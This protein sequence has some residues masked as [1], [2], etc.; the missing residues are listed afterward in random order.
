MALFCIFP[1]AETRIDTFIH[2]LGNIGPNPC[3]PKEISVEWVFYT[4]FA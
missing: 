3:F 1:R 2:T 4:E